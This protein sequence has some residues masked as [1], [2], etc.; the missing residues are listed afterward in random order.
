MRG[1]VIIAGGR[2]YPNYF[3]I[4]HLE[5]LEV[6]RNNI[7]ILMVVS[8]GC[9]GVDKNAIQWALQNNIPFEEYLADWNKYGKIA[10]YIRN[11]EMAKNSDGVILFPGGKGTKLMEKISLRKKLPIWYIKL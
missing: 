7:P 3:N 9:A 2:D 4:R 8:G 5:E 10:G 6:L 11:E 1:R